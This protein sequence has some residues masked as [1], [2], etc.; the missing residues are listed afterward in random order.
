M[1][2]PELHQARKDLGMTQA[3]LAAAIG[4][5]RVTVARW[6]SGELPIT[7]RTIATLKLLHRRPKRRPKVEPPASV[8]VDVSP[9]TILGDQ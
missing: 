6:E 4:V 3:E 9:P 2:G 7:L 8:Q 1:T 5:H